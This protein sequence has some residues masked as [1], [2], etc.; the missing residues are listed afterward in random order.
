MGNSVPFPSAMC[1]FRAADGDNSSCLDS[2]EAFDFVVWHTLLPGWSTSEGCTYHECMRRAEG[3]KWN[4]SRIDR[5][6]TLTRCV[7]GDV[8]GFLFE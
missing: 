4:C 6:E 3:A 5:S 2:Q 1:L 8:V 7:L